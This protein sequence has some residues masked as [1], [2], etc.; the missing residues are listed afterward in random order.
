MTLRDDIREHF[1]NEAARFPSPH[2][3]ESSVAAHAA[4]QADEP[5]RL[6]WVPAAVA[7]LLG[8]AIIAG[9]LA[10]GTLRHLSTNP[11]VPAG[12]VPV[13]PP[14][15]VAGSG[16]WTRVSDMST[17]R[18]NFT[19]TLLKSG[20]VLVVGG[21]VEWVVPGNTT[22]S[23]EIYDPNTRKFTEAASLGSPRAGQTATLLPDGRVLVAGGYTSLGT[24]ALSSTEI[25]D[26]ANDT[27]TPG[28]PMSLARAQAAAVLLK[29]GTVLVVGGGQTGVMG[30]G[31][32][33][34]GTLAET[35]DPA[36]DAWMP[37]GNMAYGRAVYPTATLLADGRVLVVGGRALFNSPETAV[38]RSEVFDPSKNRWSAVPANNRTGSRQDQSATLL[39]NG[40][41]LIAGGSPIPDASVSYS[42][43]FS[44][45]TNSWV[46]IPNMHS[47]RCGQGAALLPSGN[48]MVIGGGCGWSD[49]ASGVEEFN[50]ST[51]TWTPVAPLSVQRGRIQAVV[52]ADGSVLALGGLAAG[53]NASVMV[54]EF[55]PS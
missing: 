37:A 19:A 50:W 38:E 24:Q 18:V 28:A 47:P 31:T 52:L 53:N 27:W 15:V 34:A 49:Q 5:R 17:P 11:D 26:P 16:R 8:I 51:G 7:V 42:D 48:A 40:D 2:G 55:N 32:Q 25:Y 36:K 30:T 23:V 41:V 39:T 12:T 43:L 29:N 9:L 4:A 21:Q 22:N 54:E 44:P 45:K 14:T 1:A 3:L 35:Y 6:H 10:A 13:A 20:K 33:P 46:S